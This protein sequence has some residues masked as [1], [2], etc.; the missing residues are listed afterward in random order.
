MQQVLAVL[1]RDL[2]VQLTYPFQ[3]LSRGIGIFVSLFTFFFLGRL[4][5]TSSYLDQYEGGY[6]AFALVGVVTMI[7]AGAALQSFTSGLG[8]DASA[9]TLE[10]LLASRVRLGVLVTGWMLYPLLLAS[11]QGM[12]MF[13]FGWFLVS[14]A[15]HLGGLLIA[16]LPFALLVLTFLAVGVAAGAFTMIS[17]R[18]DPISGIYLSVSTLLAGAV[19]PVEVLPEWLQAI[20][21]LFPAFYGFRAIREAL[22]GGGTFAD[23][24]G[25]VLILVAFNIVLLPLGMWALRRAL[26]FARVMGTL[27]TS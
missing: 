25:D 10:I 9:G 24:R 23:I 12:V 26:H 8:S 4:V 27:A 19:F 7:L 18:G 11:V 17:K 20:A 14:E 21:R 5:G 6:F 15:F 2:Q 3:F 1:R 16:V 22:I 13:G